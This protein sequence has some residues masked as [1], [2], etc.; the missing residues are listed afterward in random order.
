M[1]QINAW[2]PFVNEALI[3]TFS[4]DTKPEIMGES[5]ELLR[6]NLSVNSLNF[7]FYLSDLRNQK[8]EAI[9]KLTQLIYDTGQ[10]SI[11][12]KLRQIAIQ[13]L[14]KLKVKPGEYYLSQKRKAEYLK[15]QKRNY[16][17]T[18]QKIVY[19][20]SNIPPPFDS[21]FEVKVFLKIHEKGYIVLPQYMD[22]STMGRR[23]DLVIMD[24]KSNDRKLAVEC[25]G[26][27]HI[28]K[29]KKKE[30]FEREQALKEWEFWRITESEFY[31]D[32]ISEENRNE[33]NNINEQSLSSLWEMLKEMNI[34]PVEQVER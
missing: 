26:D 17:K 7:W 15:K 23:I 22:E 16:E 24:A 4:S 33:Y 27:F 28:E 9:K 2:Y 18:G 1:N 21:F 13:A 14:N 34:N 25:D 8:R 5:V 19:K 30:D 31:N 11:P 6:K 29:N 3:D 20:S 12:H 32:S 10:K